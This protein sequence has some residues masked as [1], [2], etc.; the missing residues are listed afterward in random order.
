MSVTYALLASAAR[1]PGIL[2]R[3]GGMLDSSQCESNRVGP[4]VVGI[5][6]FANGERT[7][8]TAA[9]SKFQWQ[10]RI[11]RQ[12]APS[13][14]FKSQFGGNKQVR[15]STVFSKAERVLGIATIR[16]TRDVLEWFEEHAHLFKVRAIDRDASRHVRTS[17]GGRSRFRSRSV[18]VMVPAR[19]QTYKQGSIGQRPLGVGDFIIP[20]LPFPPFSDRRHRKPPSR[21]EWSEPNLKRRIWE[22]PGQSPGCLPLHDDYC[23]ICYVP[24]IRSISELGMVDHGLADRCARLL[25]AFADP[26]RLRIVDCLRTGTKCVTELSRLLDTEIV[27][28]SHHLRVMRES[29]VVKAARQGRQIYY[30]LSTEHFCI[31]SSKSMVVDCNWCRLEILHS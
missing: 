14:Q 23:G 9:K 18:D 8:N 24:S 1:G 4:M 12:D 5:T 2:R 28:I 29:G 21:G 27:N 17:V 31:E 7:Y 26:T 19:N 13:I 25:S 11:L 3:N 16:N 20:E 22:I 6:H 10:V 30:S 15:H